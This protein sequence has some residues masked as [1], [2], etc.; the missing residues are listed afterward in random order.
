MHRHT[1]KAK[2]LRSVI[3]SEFTHGN[4]LIYPPRWNK[5]YAVVW[6]LIHTTRRVVYDDVCVVYQQRRIFE[7]PFRGVAADKG[8]EITGRR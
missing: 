6:R 4:Y 8:L 2:H 3:S 1:D 7:I 5:Q